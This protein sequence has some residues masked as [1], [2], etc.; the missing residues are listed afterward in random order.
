V[1]KSFEKVVFSLITSS[2]R[3]KTLAGLIQPLQNVVGLY[4][5]RMV[6]YVKCC[7]KFINFQEN[8][9]LIMFETLF[10]KLICYNQACN[11]AYKL[12]S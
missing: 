6:L 5:K 9:L 2:S 7:T 4:Y 3:I 8:E 1:L 12:R 10:K 11:L